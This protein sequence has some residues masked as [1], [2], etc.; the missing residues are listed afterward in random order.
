VHEQAPKLRGIEHI[1]V[2][3]DGE[4]GEGGEPAHRV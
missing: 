4:P 1:G 2:V 3:E